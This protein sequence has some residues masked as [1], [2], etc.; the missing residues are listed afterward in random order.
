MTLSALNSRFRKS[1]KAEQTFIV[2]VLVPSD[3]VGSNA[4]GVIAANT[5]GR[6]VE[7]RTT[8]LHRSE[9]GNSAFLP[10]ADGSREL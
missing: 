7:I 2:T 8:L 1:H 9:G 3:R 5:V 6:P 10:A 4:A